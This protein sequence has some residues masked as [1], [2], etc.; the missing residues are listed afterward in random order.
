MALPRRQTPVTGSG[1]PTRR[2]ARFS[3][4][5]GQRVVRRWRYRMAPDPLTRQP[6][7]RIPFWARARRLL[8]SWWIWAVLFLWHMG[9]NAWGWAVGTGGMALVSYLITPSEFPPRYGLDHELATDDE[10]FLPTMT[11]ATGVPCVPGNRID[12]LNNGDQFYPAMLDAVAHAEVSITIEAYIYWAGEIGHRF[13]TALAAKASAGLRVKI[14][15]DAVGST[16]V[17]E[18][19]LT[20]LERGGCQ[21]AWYNPIRYYSIGRF[22]HRTHRKSLIIDGR[23]AFTGGAGI[24]DHWLGDAR[25]PTEWRDMQIR[26]EGP[27]VTPLQTG[28]AHNWLQTTGELISGPLFYPVPTTAGPLA[29]QTIMSS[30]ETGASTARIMYYLSIICARRSIY[31]ANPYFLPDAAAMDALIEAKR[32]GVDVKIM[33]SGIHND[34][35]L[36]RRNSVRLFGPLLRAG[37]EILEFNRTMLHHKTMVV[38]TLWTTVGTTNFDN[39]SFAHNEENNVCC[40]DR[41]FARRFQEMFDADISGCDRVLLEHWT[42]RGVRQRLEELVAALLE[43]Q[44]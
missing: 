13:A 19:I 17:G 40:H 32:R 39:R 35:W 3:R 11:G 22:N 27:A 25:D 10:E 38:D 36:A 4:L 34:N 31:I 42:H 20:V 23:I 16:R 30:P 15:L 14:L 43:E 21:L 2:P 1:R 29:A 6:K 12:I 28:F 33:V 7:G 5:R 8:W 18:E 24:A 41:A 37:I 26:I 44:T 9:H